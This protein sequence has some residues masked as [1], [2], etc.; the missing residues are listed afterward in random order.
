MSTPFKLEKAMLVKAPS[1]SGLLDDIAD[2][3]SA[4]AADIGGM[5]GL[6]A[7]PWSGQEL[8]FRFNPE[9]LNLSKAANYVEK[10]RSGSQSVDN[11]DPSP[12]QYVGSSNRTLSFD[13]LLDEW[14]APPGAGRD[15]A[16]M[17]AAL[18]ALMDINPQPDDPVPSP[19]K[20]NFHW[21]TFKFQG[22]LTR[23]DAIF[24]LFRQ[25]GSPAR[26]EVSIAMMEHIEAPRPTNP[27]SG[28]PPGRRSRVVIE[29]DNLHLLSYREFGKSGYWRALADVNGIDDPLSLRPGTSLLVPSRADAQTLR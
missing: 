14:D 1:E 4:T 19:P 3:A 21:G 9:K 22:Y 26:A 23:A 10:P 6:V 24:T 5:S 28:G 8:H 18:Q 29:G 2:I 27:T 7:A 15:V 25:D 12:P 13:V 20:M 17:V 16:E 11:T